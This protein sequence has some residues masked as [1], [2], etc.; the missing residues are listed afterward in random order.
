MRSSQEQ[1]VI[2]MCLPC[3]NLLA[4]QGLQLWNGF[5]SSKNMLLTRNHAIR[6]I[7]KDWQRSRDIN[8]MLIYLF[9]F[10]VSTHYFHHP[11]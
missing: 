1:E 8:Q 5:L 2:S 9:R 4:S 10:V 7:C 6:R 11:K 3:L